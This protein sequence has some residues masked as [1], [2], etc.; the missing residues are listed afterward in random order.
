MSKPIIPIV[1][2]TND[3][4]TYFCYTAVYSTIKYANSDND[5]RIYIFVTSVSDSNCKLLE[6]LSNY[7]VTVECIDVS[8]FTSKVDLRESLHLSIE[9]Y[10]RLFIPLILPQYDKVL[11][12][13]S[14]MCILADVADLYNEDISGFPV[15]AVLDVP[16][17][18]LK[19]HSIEI[20]NLDC[21]KTFNAGVLLMNCVEFEAQ[22]IR[23]KCLKLLE[24]DYKQKERKLIFADQDALNIALYENYKCI[25]NKWNYQSQYLW[26]TDN[27]F[28]EYRQEYIEN[29]DKA[30]IMHFAGDR[31]PWN[32]PSQEKAEVYWSIAK[33][34]PIFDK[35]V[36]KIITDLREAANTISVFEQFQFPYAKVPFG[37]KIA[38]YA[39]GVVGRTFYVQ[40]DKSKYAEVV[41]WVDQN[42]GS[43]FGDAIIEDI[44]RL[45]DTEY[46]YL[47]IA[48]DN[49]LTANAIMNNL[50]KMGIDESKIVWQEY[51]K[52]RNNK[53]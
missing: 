21:L 41:V 1:F 47:V 17:Y 28:S 38:L 33:E 40:M 37:S 15:G 42:S 24:E 20:A 50:L 39:A 13:D 35:I 32:Y 6:S 53:K 36:N 25:D 31:K 26:R 27:L 52:D 12:L 5:Y 16:C 3:T 18:I 8:E 29:A 11:Y 44:S 19:E 51:L 48:I 49:K 14:D 10:Y 45:L 9:T 2:A 7:Y 22:R 46:E 34:T 30:Y 43:K 23:E 4:Y